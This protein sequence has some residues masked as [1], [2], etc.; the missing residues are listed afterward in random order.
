MA[1]PTKKSVDANSQ[2]GKGVFRDTWWTQ[3]ISVMRPTL[4]G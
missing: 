1:T 2:G 3:I 4:R